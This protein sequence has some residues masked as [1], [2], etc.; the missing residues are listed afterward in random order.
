MMGVNDTV[1]P[2]GRKLRFGGLRQI[3]ALVLLAMFVLNAPSARAARPDA[4][5]AQAFIGGL[6]DDASKALRGEGSLSEREAKLRSLL[7]KGFAIDLI[8]QVALG[9]HWRRVSATERDDYTTEFGEFL[10]R[11]YASRLGGFDRE[12][13]EVGEAVARGKRDVIVQTRIRQAGNAPAI[14]A[15]WRIRQVNGELRII[16][17]VVEGVSMVLNQR[18]EF[19]QIVRTRGM[20]ALIEMLRARTQRAPIEGP[21]D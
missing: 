1:R 2:G 10:L 6:A 16:D 9:K 13:F 21:K 3:G 19:A 14:K 12:A 5:A 20:S 17:I 11:T 4:D 7:R 15:G 18:Q 8:A